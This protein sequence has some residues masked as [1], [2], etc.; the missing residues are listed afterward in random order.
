M[1]FPKARILPTMHWRM[2]RPPTAGTPQLQGLVD[3]LTNA[4]P[5]ALFNRALCVRVHMLELEQRASSLP[6]N[7]EMAT[8]PRPVVIGGVPLVR[9]VSFVN[10]GKPCRFTK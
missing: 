4:V 8:R 10:V 6:C 5:V 3:G 9:K 7:Y 1:D 2:F